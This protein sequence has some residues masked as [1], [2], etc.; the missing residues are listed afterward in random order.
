MSLDPYLALALALLCWAV[1]IL[2]VFYKGAQER[3]QRR[4]RRAAGLAG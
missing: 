3:R 2:F 1:G 4:A